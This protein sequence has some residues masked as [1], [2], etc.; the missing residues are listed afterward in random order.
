MSDVIHHIYGAFHVINIFCLR[1]LLSF[2][3]NER[4]R[5]MVITS[6]KRIHLI[7]FGSFTAYLFLVILLNSSSPISFFEWEKWNLVYMP[8]AVCTSVMFYAINFLF[9]AP[10]FKDGSKMEFFV[11]LLIVAVILI[12]IRMLAL[13]LTITDAEISK[14]ALSKV[15]DIKQ[16]KNVKHAASIGFIMGTE[17]FLIVILALGEFVGIGFLSTWHRQQVSFRSKL[18]ERFEDFKTN[19]TLKVIL[20][21]VLGWTIWILLNNFNLLIKGEFIGIQ[22]DLLLLI[23][24]VFCFYASFYTSF[25]FLERNQLFLAIFW[26][27]ILWISFS[28]VKALY[29][30]ILANA[31]LIPLEHFGHPNSKTISVNDFKNSMKT[32]YLV[33]FS[34]SKIFP[35]EMY[36]ILVSFIYGY[37]RNV[38]R[39]KNQLA[40]I[41]QQRQQE[42]IDQQRIETELVTAKLQTLKYQINPHFL[43]NSLNFLYAQSIPLSDNLSRATMLLSEI[44]RYGLQQNDE[45]KVALENEIKHLENFVEFNRL[46]FSNRLQINFTIEGNTA[47]RRIMPLLLITFVENAF[48]YGELHDPENPLN[49]S[50]KIDSKTLYFEVRNKKRNGPKENSTGIGLTNIK[51]R[52]E[53]AYPE[54]HSLEIIDEEQFFTTKLKIEL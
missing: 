12:V 38:M 23:P 5:P 35:K 21:N 13:K 50:L 54:N 19:T 39:Y 53:L 33:G 22:A 44:M 34:F 6:T 1:G 42:L 8:F 11:I 52:L 41:E 46:R 28:L 49:I 16:T 18:I 26:T 43:F 4:N 14:Y 32:G 27:L 2:V 30:G 20:W 9:I 45:T 48:K 24:S 3:K 15:S 7:A 47:F 10:V 31:G 40:T 36:I 25:R 17:G 29:F 37:A 51:S